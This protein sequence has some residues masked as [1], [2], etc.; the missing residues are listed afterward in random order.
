MASR[1]AF[2]VLVRPLAKKMSLPVSRLRLMEL[3]T[4]A[5]PRTENGHAGVNRQAPA[6][7]TVADLGGSIAGWRLVPRYSP[8]AD[9]LG[10]LPG[11]P[12]VRGTPRLPSPARARHAPVA[13]GGP[14]P[15]SA[16]WAAA[17]TAVLRGNTP[18]AIRAGVGTNNPGVFT[19]PC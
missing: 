17:F 10:F 13:S 4:L 9:L 2:S 16:A 7:P 19:R 1:T 5:T 8:D 6:R 18:M 11:S 3:D 14:V 12:R 15:D